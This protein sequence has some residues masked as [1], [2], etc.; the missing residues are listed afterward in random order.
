MSPGQP[1]LGRRTAARDRPEEPLRDGALRAEDE[2]LGALR[3]DDEREG[4]ARAELRPEL[5]LGAAE[6]G[7]GRLLRAELRLGADL[8]G[9]RLVALDGALL[10]RLG[11]TRGAE[12]TRL[13]VACRVPD[14]D[15]ADRV[16]ALGRWRVERVVDEGRP[17]LDRRAVGVARADVARLDGAARVTVR[18]GARVPDTVDRVLVR[19]RTASEGRARVAVARAPVTRLPAARPAEARVAGA[20]AR[21]AVEFRRAERAT[22]ADTSLRAALFALGVVVPDR[23]VATREAE[24]RRGD[25]L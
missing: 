15:G 7:V 13:G 6:R 4:A 25:S 22:M 18:L 12:R 8:D 14:L 5:R 2:R 1:P 16:V 10:A 3:V 20:A 17:V 23:G 21:L 11:A 9:A 19:L 24:V